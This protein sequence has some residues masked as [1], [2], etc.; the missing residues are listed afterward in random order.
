MRGQGVVRAELAV[1][2]HCGVGEGGGLVGWECGLA[3]MGGLEGWERC[4]FRVGRHGRQGW[5]EARLG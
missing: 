2:A 5:S 1:P 4:L 3:E